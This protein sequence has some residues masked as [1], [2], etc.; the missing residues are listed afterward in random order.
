MKVT[1][2]QPSSGSILIRIESSDVCTKIYSSSTFDPYEKL[3]IWLSQ[4][5]DSQL[6][7][8]MVIDEE[9]R[10]VELIAER[11]NNEAILFR[12]Q[13]WFQREGI[14]TFLTATV[15]LQELLEAFHDGIVEFITNEYRPFDWSYIDNLSNRNWGTLLKPSTVSSRNW[16]KR[17]LISK[18]RTHSKGTN[19]EVDALRNQLTLEQEWLLVLQNILIEI[20]IYVGRNKI[21]Q[22]KVLANLY[23]NLPVDI[24]LNEI[25][26]SWY[27]ER[28][29]K[30]NA[31]YG[32]D[33]SWWTNREQRE[34]HQNLRTA[35]LKTLKVGQVVD[36]T[37]FAVKP[38]GIFVDIGGYGALL[39]ISAISQLTVEHPEQVFQRDDWVRAMIIW[40]DVERGRVSLSTSD[41]EPEPGDMLK[42]PLKVYEKAEEMA[43]RY[44]QHVL[45]KQ[46]QN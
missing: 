18:L 15:E 17:L 3:Y 22:V 45:S 5:R 7:T 37:V 39:H 16:Q 23:K 28:R 34:R 30:L 19:P 44:Y 27:Q 38:Y 8:T 6:P 36:G 4:I 20:A 46:N 35:R 2:I 41:L 43:A 21:T 33:L 1:L 32:L 13:P 12:I 42:D 9:G 26:P 11:A 10:G 40:M 14:T 24:L 25:D 29:N 31:E